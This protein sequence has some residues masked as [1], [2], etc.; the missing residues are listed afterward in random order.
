MYI[1]FL[2]LS[3]YIYIYIHIHTSIRKQ[4][5]IAKQEDPDRAEPRRRRSAH[6]TPG[7][8]KTWLE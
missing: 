2:S 7:D 1:F 6:V 5:L 4:L 8:V 3:L